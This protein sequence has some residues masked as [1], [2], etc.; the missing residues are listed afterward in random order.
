[1]VGSNLELAAGMCGSESGW[2]PVTVGQPTIKV[3][4]ILVGGKGE[5]IH[6]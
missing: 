6:E 3:D 1:M 4:K 2:I 5:K